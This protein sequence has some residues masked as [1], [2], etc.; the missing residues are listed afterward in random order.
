MP[1]G[2][3]NLFAQQS[4][5]CAAY[6]S[7]QEIPWWRFREKAAQKEF[8]DWLYPLMRQEMKNLTPSN[9]TSLINQK[10]T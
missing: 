10:N 2:T 1:P 9:S 7:Y 6:V 4:M 5:F 3:I 8:C